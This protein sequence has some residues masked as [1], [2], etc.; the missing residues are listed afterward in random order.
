MCYNTKSMCCNTRIMCCNIRIRCCDA[1]MC[2]NAVMCFN[3]TVMCCHTTVMCCITQ[4]TGLQLKLTDYFIFFW[5]SVKRQGHGGGEYIFTSTT[6]MQSTEWLLTNTANVH[7]NSCKNVITTIL[8][9]LCNLKLQLCEKKRTFL[10]TWKGENWQIGQ[11]SVTRRVFQYRKK[12]FTYHKKLVLCQHSKY[13][14]SENNSK[15]KCIKT[16]PFS[17]TISRCC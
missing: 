10:L 2:C 9:D 11:H 1:T 15:M 13:D 5:V 8:S 14:D 3:T 4:K 17:W 16:K 12:L 6:K 7:S